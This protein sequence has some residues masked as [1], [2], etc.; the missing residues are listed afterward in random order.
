[1]PTP[2]ISVASP[3]GLW[4]PTATGR[5]SALATAVTVRPRIMRSRTEAAIAVSR[6]ARAVGASAPGV[7][8]A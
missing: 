1:M 5:P 4:L 8:R 7:G 3:T 2:T 6:S